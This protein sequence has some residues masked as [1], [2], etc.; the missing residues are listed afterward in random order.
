MRPGL[1]LASKG[2]LLPDERAQH[3]AEVAVVNLPRRGMPEANGL[4]RREGGR[5]ARQDML[6]GNPRTPADE[7]RPQNAVNE[8]RLGLVLEKYIRPNSI[9]PACMPLDDRLC[10]DCG[11]WSF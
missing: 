4:K 6:E 11:A 1:E 10:T 2:L 3:R 5:Q 9:P 7:S 8:H